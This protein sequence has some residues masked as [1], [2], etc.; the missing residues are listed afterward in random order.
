MPVL[1]IE[2]RR[3]RVDDGFSDLPYSQ[4]NA[5]VDKIAG[6]LKLQPGA[7]NVEA[8]SDVQSA[9]R[10]T[11]FANAFGRGVDKV[12]GMAYSAAEAVGEYGGDLPGAQSLED[13][14]TRGRLREQEQAAEHGP[15]AEF[16]GIRSVGDLGQWLKETAGDQLP[17]FAPAIGGGVAGAAIGGPLGFAIGAAIPLAL[18]AGETQLAVKRR[19]E[20]VEAPG[21]AFVGGS[22]IAALDRIV[23]GRIGS[24]LVSALGRETAEAAAQR[25]LSKPVSSRV[26]TEGGKGVATEG[27]TEALQEAVA[28]VS[29]A[30]GTKTP[31][32]GDLPRQMVEAGAAGAVMGGGSQALTAPVMQ[33][34]EPEAMSPEPA[35]Q[36][37]A[38]VPEEPKPPTRP[39]D[40]LLAENIANAIDASAAQ[41][42]IDPEYMR[43][44]AWIESRGNPNAQ[45]PNSSA[46][47]LFQFIDDTAKRYGL[48]DR[49][50]PT[51]NA[52]AAA[53]LTR[54]NTIALTEALGREPSMGELY[55]AH[56]QGANGAIA[57]LSRADE[58]AINVVGVDAVTDNGG[59]MTMTA[60]DFANLWTS[61]LDGNAVVG[62]GP[63]RDFGPAPAVTA[64]SGERS[65]RQLSELQPGAS[66]TYPRLQ[67]ILDDERTMD[68][69]RADRAPKP[70]AAR[71]RPL[72]VGNG[73]DLAAAGS[74]VN[75]NPT[76]AQKKAGNY[77]KGHVKYQ[78]FDITI[79][80]P[81][82]SIRSGTDEN[83]QPWS[84]T[85]PTDYGY[86][87]RTNG[88]DGDQIDVYLG[89]LTDAG[90]VF[91]IDQVDPATGKFDEAKAMLG[92]ASEADAL[93]TYNAA[94]NDGSGQA[95]IGA[96]TPMPI[97]QFR[98][99]V[100]SGKTKKPFAYQ[101]PEDR[102]FT[103]EGDADQLRAEMGG[104]T[105]AEVFAGQGYQIMGQE[106]VFGA[107]DNLQRL[108]E[109]MRA[110]LDR[111]G[112]KH[113]GL[114]L[115][116]E[117]RAVVGG[118]SYNISGLF[119]DSVIN[120]ALA[121]KDKVGT[122]RHEA[123]HALVDAG[124][125][126]KKEWK[127]L[128]RRAE[129]D[130]M[131]KYGIAEKYEHLPRLLQVEEAIAHAYA[132]WTNKRRKEAGLVARAFKKIRTFLES[133]G[134]ALRGMGFE[135]P[136]QVFENVF[137]GK[138]GAR[139]EA[140]VESDSAP[141]PDTDSGQESLSM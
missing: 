84:V 50:D 111:H 131:A 16:V 66:T 19:G 69:I 48:T 34:V 17:I 20:D 95:R 103:F 56:Q 138:I 46:S 130:W 55:L 126:T 35:S 102:I 71:G 3:V 2:G 119:L 128:T 30:H 61:K 134:N 32:S 33:G 77:R 13:F 68:E 22:A 40:G 42:G 12:Q 1:N 63:A 88:A 26:L 31:V 99:W 113:V 38:S 72:T 80:N 93:A 58:P 92:F 44:V 37:V 127:L 51:Q 45:N 73:A 133:M 105:G 74:V 76:E 89:P 14:G 9:E 136:D 86:L 83:G 122:L 78:G 75:T 64:R 7:R 112:L 94:F 36:V 107:M 6:N 118:T 132:D 116:E 47:G 65:D 5:V 140:D 115:F 81:M 59:T 141:L 62:V 121:G 28:E 104:P 123:L 87:K 100:K 8:G 90:T 79:E 21:M 120:V 124:V 70:V 137:A 67:E 53:R 85:M 18:G 98:R 15:Q 24:R 129:K 114:R 52:D 4:Q 27:L 41:Y 25:A 139:R 11:S 101:E 91:L 57:L 108:E 43:R 23:P 97:S 10:D 109:L 54:D 96:V 117:M 110:D 39:T 82:G 29:A 60:G 125:F 106:P 135:T 49:F